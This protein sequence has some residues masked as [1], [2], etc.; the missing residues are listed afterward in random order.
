MPAPENRPSIDVRVLGAL[1]LR[2][3]ADGDALLS[4]PKRLAVFL[5]L[6]L[7]TPRGFHRRDKV[8]GLFWPESDQ[9]RARAAM[10]KALHAIRQALGDGIVVTRGDDDVSIASDRVRCD[11]IDFDAAEAAGQYARMLDLYRGDL[12]EGFFAEAPGF[13]RWLE[14]ARARRQ[15]SA[16]R[17]AWTMAELSETGADLTLAA[18][19]AR[20][21]AR[22][23]RSDERRIRKAMLLLHRAG[24]RAGAIEVYESFSRALREDLDV[25]P[26]G[27]TQTLARQIRSE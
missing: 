25:A 19:W 5:Y 24:D 21:A 1:E 23:A 13:E 10:R 27:E 14:D 4:Q 26:S 20:Q 6:L 7:A 12:L 9:E 18:H 3:A 2:G 15:E 11:V 16:A 17:A 8:M 22:L